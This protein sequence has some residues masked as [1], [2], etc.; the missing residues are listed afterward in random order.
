MGHLSETLLWAEVPKPSLTDN[1]YVQ[2]DML[3]TTVQP[4][5]RFKPLG[6]NLLR[7]ECANP[8]MLCMRSGTAKIYGATFVLFCSGSFPGRNSI[9][10]HEKEL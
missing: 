9:T 5:F 1:K 3:K 8:V 7:L 2:C 10:T 4:E 6:Q